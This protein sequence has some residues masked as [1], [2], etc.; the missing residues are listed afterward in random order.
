MD[1]MTILTPNVEN[2]EHGTPNT[3]HRGG[4]VW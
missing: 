2:V 3:Y 4:T 1:L